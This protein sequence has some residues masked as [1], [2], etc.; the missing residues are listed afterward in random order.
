MKNALKSGVMTIVTG[1]R[2]TSTNRFPVFS[3][4]PAYS[5]DFNFKT[6]LTARKY[7]G[8]GGVKHSKDRALG[9]GGLQEP[10]PDAQRQLYCLSKN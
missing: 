2:N 5:A 9:I 4:F 6:P 10:K 1:T 3:Q 7:R 8:Q